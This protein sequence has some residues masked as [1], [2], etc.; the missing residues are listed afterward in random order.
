MSRIT[1][2]SWTLAVIAIAPTCLIGCAGP[3]WPTA[4]G[5]VDGTFARNRH[6][7][8]AV[9][10]L[11]P[12][13]QVWTGKHSA[14]HPDAIADEM[15]AAARTAAALE[16]AD[17]GYGTAAQIDWDGTAAVLSGSRR[18]V[19]DP[20][21]VAETVYALSGYGHA[22]ASA[23]QGLLVPYLPHLLGQSTGSDATLYIGGWSY[24]G[25]DPGK[26]AGSGVAEGIVIGLLVVSVVAVLALLLKD[27]GGK[28]GK[29]GKGAGRALSSAGRVASR[30]LRP[31]VRGVARAGTAFVRGVQISGDAF[32]HLDTH[33]H[34]YPGRPAYFQDPK[35]P[36]EGKS[37]MQIEMTLVDNR[38]G[39]VLWHSSETF[40]AHALRATDVHKAV[41]I[42]LSSLPRK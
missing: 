5:Q 2:L 19:M 13:I 27:S 22:V 33:V 23:G 29:V 32:G 31:A 15:D 42:M 34:V 35:T 26:S 39:T 8:R 11:P 16:L 6:Q 40:P 18:Q 12:D 7:I 28:V 37:R 9:D 25:K 4:R 41:T 14:H 30:A 20:K 17:R 21:E 10:I 24:V 1:P 3:T 38:T 36:K